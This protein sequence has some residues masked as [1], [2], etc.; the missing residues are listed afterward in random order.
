MIRTLFLGSLQQISP[1]FSR[2]VFVRIEQNQNATDRPGI[3][4]GK[5]NGAFEFSGLQNLVAFHADRP[6]NFHCEI[7]RDPLG[8]PS[9]QDRNGVHFTMAFNDGRNSPHGSGIASEQLERIRIHVRKIRVR[10]ELVHAQQL[11][12]GVEMVPQCGAT[13]FVQRTDATLSVF[14]HHGK[15]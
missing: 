3:Q 11:A 12:S 15:D 10:V 9:K 5:S 6:R 1:E 14:G 4:C 7:R 2:A 13:C 8:D